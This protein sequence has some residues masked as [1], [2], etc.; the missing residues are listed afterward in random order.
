MLPQVR[1]SP[2][3]QRDCGE[4]QNTTAKP[5]MRRSH[6]W[7]VSV[8]HATSSKL[9]GSSASRSLLKDGLREEICRQ[10]R[11]LQLPPPR[12]GPPTCKGLRKENLANL[13][14]SNPYLTH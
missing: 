2:H 8:A 13:P 6:R 5:V 3:G 1:E 12:R 14:L 9:K 10:N 11:R 4:R 7:N